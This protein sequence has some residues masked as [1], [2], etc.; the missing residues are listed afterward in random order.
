MRQVLGIADDAA[1]M[2]RVL[3]EDVERVAEDLVRRHREQVLHGVERLEAGLVDVGDVEVG[4]AH[5]DVDRHV[6]EHLQQPLG[7]GFKPRLLGRELPGQHRSAVAAARIGHRRHGEIERLAADGDARLVRQVLRIGQEPALMLRVLVKDVDRLSD[8]RVDFHR[9]NMLDLF[10]ILP[11]RLVDVGDLEIVQLA[12]HDTDRH[13][14]EQPVRTV[15]ADYACDALHP[16]HALPPALILICERKTM[17]LI[18][19]KPQDGG[20]VRYTIYNL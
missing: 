7:L 5:H 12:E 13:V 2:R 17:H 1:L 20:Q 14:V 8:Q 3:V 16:Q 18:G 4:I 11:R 6:V 10:Q 19:S 15:R 9:Q